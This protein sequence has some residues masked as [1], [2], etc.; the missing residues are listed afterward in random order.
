MWRN[1]ADSLEMPNDTQLGSNAARTKPRLFAGVAP[2]SRI[3]S[4]L[5]T[6]QC[7]LQ[8]VPLKHIAGNTST[9]RGMQASGRQA[10]FSFPPPKINPGVLKAWGCNQSMPES[11]KR[12]S[13]A[14]NQ[15]TCTLRVQQFLDSNTLDVTDRLMAHPACH[16]WEPRLVLL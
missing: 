12:G 16:R 8:P 11:G 14:S 15:T 9:T 10:P 5:T 6:G 1:G 4:L 2:D 13:V 7:E 3:S